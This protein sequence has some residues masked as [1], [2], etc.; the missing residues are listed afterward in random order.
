MELAH[1]NLQFW[2]NHG[3]A[4]KSSDIYRGF[5]L[6]GLIGSVLLWNAHQ[7]SKCPTTKHSKK[8]PTWSPGSLTY[9]MLYN[10]YDRFHNLQGHYSDWNI[11]VHLFNACHKLKYISRIF[12]CLNFFCKVCF[13]FWI[14]QNFVGLHNACVSTPVGGMIL[15][16]QNYYDQITPTVHH[17]SII[18]SIHKVCT[19]Y[20]LPVFDSVD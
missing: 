9:F 14:R 20:Y 18:Y 4:Y 3:D 2:H 16:K 6:L 8:C 10:L 11:V 15:K 5:V 7:L 1:K 19:T 12:L 17:K 13:E